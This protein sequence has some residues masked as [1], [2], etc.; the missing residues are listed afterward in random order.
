MTQPLERR[1][2]PGVVEVRDKKPGVRTIG[3]YAAVFNKYSSNLGG[4][5][6]QVAPGA[7]NRS[8]GRGFPGV[9]ARHNHD[10][11]RLLGTT[12]AETLR[13]SIDE[14]GLTYEVDPPMSRVDVV[15]LVERGDVR[16]SSFAF[17]KVEDEWG[18]T[19]QG[20]LLRTLHEVRLID[21]APVNSPAY[22]DATVALRSLADKFDADPEEVR[23]MAQ[24][25]ELRR[26]FRRTDPL[27][28]KTEASL[29]LRRQRL[30]LLQQR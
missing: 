1:Y 25:N 13:L 24:H 21:V 28:P 12:A 23:N 19:D 16:Q 29:A 18:E 10:D 7:F 20:V 26:L 22:P 4:F 15:E 14:N 5:V 30:D 27:D 17:S 9:I 11:N 8:N 6:E 2:N 3:G